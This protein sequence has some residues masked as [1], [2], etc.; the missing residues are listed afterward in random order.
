MSHGRSAVV[1]EIERCIHELTW[2]DRRQFARQVNQF[3]LSALQYLGLHEI[4]QLGPNVTMGHVGEVIQ[5]SPSSMT[6]IVDR[7]VETG[8]VE[9]GATSSDRRA[10]VVSLT[11]GGV[12]L[13]QRVEA[14]R[15]EH[16]VD[17][18]KD[19]PDGDLTEM[20]RLLGVLLKGL[21]EH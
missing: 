7:L 1:H 5:V 6:N 3:Q 2:R 13:I 21:N 18:L 16:L 4:G 15:H 12:E 17:A 9:R 11:P 8:L 19:Q 14:I 20:A 10:V